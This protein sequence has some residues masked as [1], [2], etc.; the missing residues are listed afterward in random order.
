MQ[1]VSIYFH[2]LSETKQSMLISSLTGHFIPIGILVNHHVYV[3]SLAST[4]GKISYQFYDNVSIPSKSKKVTATDRTWIS[5]TTLKD[6][7][8]ILLTHVM[9][10]LS[11]M[12]EEA[13]RDTSFQSRLMWSEDLSTFIDGMSNQ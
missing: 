4:A 9:S 5:C 10:T 3:C 11:D 13:W 2:F 6:L 12:K 8:Q 7:D 1:P